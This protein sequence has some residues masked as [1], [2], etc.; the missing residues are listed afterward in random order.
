MFCTV[1]IYDVKYPLYTFNIVSTLFT[2][3]WLSMLGLKLQ[4]QSVQSVGVE[5]ALLLPPGW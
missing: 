2:A 5:K 4:Q 1:Y 3:V